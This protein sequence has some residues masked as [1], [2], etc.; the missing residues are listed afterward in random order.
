[1]RK[2]GKQPASRDDG[3]IRFSV[4]KAATT[5]T[6]PTPPARFGHAGMYGGVRWQML[7]NGPDDSVQPGFQGAGDCVFAGAAHET[8]ETNRLAGRDVTI[9]GANA[10]ADYAAVTG[11]R[12]GDDSTDQGTD[13]RTA[14]KYRQKT[15]IVDAH[16]KRHRIG[17]YVSLTPGDWAELR[18][19]VWLFAAVG[20]GVEF[21]DSA[22]EQFAN[23]EPWDVVPD[24]KVVGG[25]YIPA[26]GFSGAHT[27]GI[28]SWGR[29]VSMTEA[30]YEAYA[31]EAWA[32]VFPEELVRGKTERGFGLVALNAALAQLGR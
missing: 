22:D 30:F 8:M 25:H 6:L 2:L 1:M 9:T 23:G 13:V 28:V 24:A 26:M 19:A 11:Y 16:G 32:V 5:Q 20:I 3:D 14:L 7:G 15:G 31:D 17:A 27:A 4:V 21:P 10:I 12:V 18:Q 29:R